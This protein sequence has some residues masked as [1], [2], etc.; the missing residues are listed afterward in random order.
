MHQLQR[1]DR[2]QPTVSPSPAQDFRRG[3]NPGGRRGQSP[4]VGVRGQVVV[5][6]RRGVRDG[7]VDRVD[8]AQTLLLLRRRRP[9]H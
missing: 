5:E 8:E 3:Q 6:R 2:H 7:H 9:R 4:P 1:V